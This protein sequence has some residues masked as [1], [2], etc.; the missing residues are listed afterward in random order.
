MIGLVMQAFW[1]G[2]ADFIIIMLGSCIVGYLVPCFTTALLRR[3]D[4]R[5]HVVLEI[6]VY[7]LMSYV[8]YVLAQVKGPTGSAIMH[9]LMSSMQCMH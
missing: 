5:G 1:I 2:I 6:S 4:L 7:L 3:V 8:P 9:H